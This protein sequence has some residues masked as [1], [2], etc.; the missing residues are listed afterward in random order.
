MSGDVRTSKSANALQGHSAVTTD[1]P[2]R[3]DRRIQAEGTR[4]IIVEEYQE[5][6][7]GRIEP[8]APR[9]EPVS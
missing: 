5:S 8:L 4:V 9:R 1:L 7:L 3:L 2:G 6:V